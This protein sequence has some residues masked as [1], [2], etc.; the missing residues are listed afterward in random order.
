[1][2][3][4]ADSLTRPHLLLH[5]RERML[6]TLRLY[7][8]VTRIEKQLT[9]YCAVIIHTSIASW[10]RHVKDTKELLH[11]LS[12]PEVDFQTR[13]SIITRKKT[14]YKQ[15]TCPFQPTPRLCFSGGSSEPP[16]KHIKLLMK[17]HLG[18]NQLI[19]YIFPLFTRHFSFSSPSQLAIA[20]RDFWIINRIT[21]PFS[22]QP[23]PPFPKGCSWTP[24]SIRTKNHRCVT[25]VF[26]ASNGPKQEPKSWVSSKE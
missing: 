19:W 5:L 16:L 1:M 3:T 2:A 20:S 18:Y 24:W 8:P 6:H 22:S 9:I 13:S 15:I 4:A 11:I 17:E 21:C 25:T 10:N 12:T 26:G 14:E 23:T 7:L